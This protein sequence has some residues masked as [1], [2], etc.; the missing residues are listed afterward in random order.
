MIS[1]KTFGVFQLRG[2]HTDKPS[3]ALAAAEK[4]ARDC[5]RH[6]RD[7]ANL[8]TGKEIWKPVRDLEL[9]HESANESATR[10]ENTY[11]CFPDHA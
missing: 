6:D 8:E 1:E 3:D 4:L 9:N 2:R 5:A 10:A 11:D 7:A